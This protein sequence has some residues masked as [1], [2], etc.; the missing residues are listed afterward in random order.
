AVGVSVS[1]ISIRRLEAAGAVIFG[2]TNVPVDLA[3]WQ[4]YNPVYG[5]TSNP[6][7]TDH[8]PGGSSGGSAAAL[9]AGLT[10]FEI[11]TDIGG[12]IRVPA[13]FCGGV[14]DQPTWGPL[15]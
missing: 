12:S 1:S 9:A 5:T 3:D 14:G 7:N 11:G 13:P 4:S 6:W 8:T 15:P 2:K 10:G